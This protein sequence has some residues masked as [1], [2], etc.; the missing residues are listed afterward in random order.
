[1]TGPNRTFSP[2]VAIQHHPRREQILPRLLAGLDGLPVEVVPDAG[3]P[4]DPWRGHLRCLERMPESFTHLVVIQD[5]AIVC[6]E[7]ACELHC[8]IE[9]EPDATLVLFL[10]SQPRLT[11]MAANRAVEAGDPFAPLHHRDYMPAVGIS[12]P[13][14]HVAD[15]LDWNSQPRARR[16]RSDDFMLGQW[17]RDRNPRV[18]VCVPSLV[19][20]PDDV[21]SV[22]GNGLGAHGRNR[23]RTALHWSSA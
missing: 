14:A 12:Y 6:D 22:I 8:S 15:V 7:F 17:H 10:A 9:A 2:V 19:Q 3:D 13:A 4:P 23:A 5:D 21:P 11:A 20:H 18:L 1:M 16:S